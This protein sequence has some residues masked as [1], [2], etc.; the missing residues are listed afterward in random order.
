MRLF[1]CVC[2]CVCVGVGVSERERERVDGW[3]GVGVRERESCLRVFVVKAKLSNQTKT[4]W[5]LWP[6][7]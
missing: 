1:V 7:S 4:N 2:V 6:Y 3:M 5:S